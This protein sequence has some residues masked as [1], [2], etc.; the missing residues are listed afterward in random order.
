MKAATLTII[1]GAFT[2]VTVAGVAG[3]SSNV[4]ISRQGN[5]CGSGNCG[6]CDTV[7]KIK[8]C[9]NAPDGKPTAG[10]CSICPC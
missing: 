9:C 6:A 10:R 2:S 5:F 8:Q 1:L 3:D 4:L 7:Q